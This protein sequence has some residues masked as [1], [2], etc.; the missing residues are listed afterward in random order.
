MIDGG[1]RPW[2]PEIKQA[3]D[4]FKQGHLIE[5]PPF[6]FA[7]APTT[8]VWGSD[9]DSAQDEEKGGAGAAEEPLVLQL[10]PE[11]CPEYGMLTSQTCDIGG[12]SAEKHPWVQVAPVFHVE[13]TEVDSFS[14]RL[15]AMRLTAPKFAD[16]RW[17]VDLRVEFPLEKGLLVGRTPI[18]AF[19]DEKGYLDFA[20]RL[21]LRRERAALA[22]S[23]VEVVCGGIKAKR[24]ADRGK[25][26]AVWDQLQA[27][28]LRLSVVEGGRLD[29]KQAR[30]HVVT[31]GEADKDARSWFDEWYDAA[32]PDAAA[33]GFALLATEFLDGTA[34]DAEHYR[35]LIDLGLI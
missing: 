1:L 20:R 23:L 2:P 24:E 3:A 31:K 11:E 13:P 28:G 10:G 30:L 14:Q 21:G 5:K 9:P 27:G 18:E 4:L 32:R 8:R 35:S 15:Y 34:V 17:F 22:D 25:A 19:A 12:L 7:A 29:P 33:H 6:F 26:R 16:G